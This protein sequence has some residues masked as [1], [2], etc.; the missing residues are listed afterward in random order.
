MNADGKKNCCDHGLQ[1]WKI[2]LEYKVGDAWYKVGERTTNASGYYKFYS[3]FPGEYRVSEV[4]QNGWSQSS[5]ADG[6]HYC[7]IKPIDKAGTLST[8]CVGSKCKNKDFLNWRPAS[9]EGH[10]FNDLNANGER[11]GDEPGLENWYIYVDYNGNGSPDTDE[12]YDITDENGYYEIDGI[13]PGTYAVRE[14]MVSGWFQSRGA[15]YVVNFVSGAHYGAEGEYD[16]GNW[17]NASK[18]GHKFNDLNAD[19]EW[20]E[21]EPGLEGWTIFVDIDGDGVFDEGEPSA[22][23]DEYGA[24]RIENIPLGTYKVYEVMQEGWTQTYPSEGY[25]EVT[26]TSGLEDTGNDFGNWGPAKIVG[27]KFEDKDADGVNDDEPGLEGWTIYVDY[28][29]DGELDT[30]EPSDVTDEHGAYEIGGVKPGTWWVREVDQNGWTQS[31]GDFQVTFASDGVYGEEGEY[32]FGNWTT[33]QL[34]GMKFHDKNGNGAKDS[35]EAGLEGWTI[36][37]TGETP[38]GTITRQTTT[39]QDGSYEFT[40]L[41]PG[42]YTISEVIPPGSDWVQS[43]PAGSTYDVTLYSSEEPEESFDFGNWSWIDP[44]GHKFHD[45]NANGAWDN[46]EPGLGGWEIHLDGTAGSGEEIHLSTTTAEDGSWSFPHVPPGSYTI[47]EV[48][49]DGWFQTF[50]APPGTYAVTYESG[51]VPTDEYDFGNYTT[52]KKYGTKFEDLNADG[53]WDNGEPGLVNWIIYVD[54]DNDGTLD[55]N[56]PFALTAQDGSYELTGVEP[57]TWWVRE[58]M[59][60]DLDW[61]QSLPGA[62]DFAYQETFTSG[63]TF[64]NNDFGNWVPAS[65]EGMKFEDLNADGVNDDE[66]G[67]EGWR[68][69]VDY[70]EDG[71]Y[72]PGE[73][74][75]LTDTDGHYE[76]TDVKPGTWWVREVL[77][78]GWTQTRGDFEVE[79]VSKGHYGAEGE[80]DFGNWYESDKRGTKFE[81]LN[82]DGVRDPGEPGLSGWTIFVDYNDNGTLDDNEPRAVTA[83]DGSYQITGIQPGTYMVYEVMK[84]DVDWTQSLPGAPD[85]GYEETF[86]SRSSMVDNDFGNWAPASIDGIKF[87]D[88]DADGEKDPNEPG[89]EGWTIFVDYDNDGVKDAD[90]P[91]DTTGPE[92]E[93]QIEGVVPGT[94][95]VR[96]V[97]DKDGWYQS[98]GDFQVTFE[99]RGSYGEEGE[100]EFGNYRLIDLDGHKFHDLDADGTWD[101]GEPGLED[102]EIHL[103]G[104]TG[105]G[106]EVH[107]TT[108]TDEDGYYSFEG[109]TPGDYTISEF[110]PAGW[111]QSYPAG[112]GT[113]VVEAHS[114]FEQEGG[115]D[116]GNWTTA[117]KYGM[118]FFDVDGDGAPRE[119]G[120]EGLEGWT[121][122]VDYNDNGV[123]DDNEPSAVT[124]EDGTYELTEILPGT[125]KVREVEDDSAWKMT[126]P[127]PGFY[128]ETFTSDEE[129]GGNDFGNTTKVVK[130]FELTFTSSAP[131]GA[132]FFVRYTVDGEAAQTPLLPTDEENVYAADVEVFPQTVIGDVEW[133]ASW[134]G[135][136]I[137]L[138]D[139]VPEETIVEDTLNEFEYDASVYGSKWNDTDYETGEPGDGIWDKATE[140][141]LADWTIQLYRQD[142]EGQWVLYATTKTGAD[143][144]YSFMG[145]LPGKYYLAEVIP[146]QD[147]VALWTQSAGPQG[148]GDLA[149]EVENGSMAGPIDFGNYE[150]FM[151][152]T[153]DMGLQ[154]TVDKPQAKPGDTLTYTLTYTMVEGAQGPDDTWTIV[155]DFDESH[156]TVVD[157]AGGTVADGKITWTFNGPLATGE[158]GTITYKMKVIDDMPSGTT[159]VDNAAVVSTDGDTNPDNNRDTARVVVSPEPYMPYTE[160]GEPFLPFTGGDAI[161]LL[162]VAGIFLAAGFAL[163]RLARHGAI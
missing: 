125:W 21:G 133:Y 81:D 161:R 46:D 108:Y 107:L 41:P 77:E 25:Y 85:F 106:D 55:E 75:A 92:G 147:G 129:K 100:Y 50:P 68:I 145:V 103:D 33:T 1:G 130:T 65:I 159:N 156:L 162:I 127:A 96:E 94:Y 47:S 34:H 78:S 128:E 30:D 142:G 83:L 14:D 116:F 141:G 56:E 27:M 17:T 126:F 139:G 11:D 123:L 84:T 49:Q 20:D 51:D 9:I 64:E 91:S 40:D 138:G 5:P 45:L 104:T 82:A 57:G 135:E 111:T 122:Y 80:Y 63:V 28:D 118:K 99:S 101:N 32:D 160:K 90:E 3:V 72:T 114:G 88:L 74:T 86:T 131:E 23:T 102:W 149:I 2:V 37:I 69:Y 44:H 155:D 39:G 152:F 22:V 35:G 146:E 89:L 31:R 52:G 71:A 18:A 121:I 93:W 124:G 98:R 70:N 4:L 67:L 150:P 134:N 158:S 38:S 120:E 109:L 58:V 163:R 66:P 137:K 29:G 154:K 143:G 10:K 117:A 13:K 115:Y 24:Y 148:E 16:F 119:S 43:Y 151:P 26:F 36:K 54:Y 110:V 113:W 73:P 97:L 153:L 15:S 76:I 53:V 59:K 87:E 112:D 157:A 42:E 132:E 105:A 136:E 144:A 7:T 19:G 8:D 60:T 95:W 140:D 62:P 79:F 12:P 6:Y 48:G 61:R